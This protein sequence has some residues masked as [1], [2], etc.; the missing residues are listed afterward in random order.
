MCRWIENQFKDMKNETTN[1]YRNFTNDP[2]G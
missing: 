2:N 1:F